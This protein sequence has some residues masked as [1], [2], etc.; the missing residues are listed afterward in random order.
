MTSSYT[1]FGR[2]PCQPLPDTPCPPCL[3]ANEPP[4]PKA[5]VS[6]YLRPPL[7]SINGQ[8]NRPASAANQPVMPEHGSDGKGWD[9]RW[10]EAEGEHVRACSG[11][12]HRVAGW[13]IGSGQGVAR[14]DAFGADG[15]TASRERSSG[16]RAEAWTSILPSSSRAI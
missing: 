1:V 3:A 16:K 6:R 13:G 8:R 12:T 9:G 15:R 5:L 7:R 14:V 2:L 4:V 11:G 10:I